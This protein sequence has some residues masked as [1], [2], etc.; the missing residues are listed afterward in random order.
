MVNLTN[1]VEPIVS[2]LDKHIEEFNKLSQMYIE[3]ASS[4]T[5]YVEGIEE[6]LINY[7]SALARALVILRRHLDDTNS[8]LNKHLD[9]YDTLLKNIKNL[10]SQCLKVDDYPGS[11]LH[12]SRNY[13][14]M[15]HIGNISI[16]VEKKFSKFAKWLWKKLLGV[17]IVDLVKVDTI[18]IHKTGF[19]SDIDELANM[20]DAGVKIDKEDT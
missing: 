18:V 1:S 11:S 20:L 8:A 15:I 10:E 2:K 19:S 4:N 12:R 3:Y 9:E 16:P 17:K 7:A 5:E 14:S 6:R 13:Q